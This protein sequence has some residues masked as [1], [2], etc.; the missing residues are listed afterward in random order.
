MV[1]SQEGIKV[2]V[3]RVVALQGQGNI[4]LMA[5]ATRL[6]NERF[7]SK[8]ILELSQLMEEHLEWQDS[9]TLIIEYYPEELS[10][11]GREL[12]A[13]D[14]F[15]KNEKGERIFDKTVSV[16]RSRVLALIQE[17]TAEKG[18]IDQGKKTA[19]TDIEEEVL[20]TIRRAEEE[21]QEEFSGEPTFKDDDDFGK[22]LDKDQHPELE[23]P[24][25]VQEKQLS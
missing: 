5:L 1:K 19:P 12:F 7:L 23:E 13:V 9:N 8:R 3:V 25:P 20:E 21:R 16:S 14:S 18:V 2:P 11:T 24:V 17:R 15:R 10:P 4:C 6:R 22:Y